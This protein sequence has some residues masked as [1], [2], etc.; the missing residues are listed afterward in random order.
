MTLGCRWPAPCWWAP[1]CYPPPQQPGEGVCL[2]W[3]TPTKVKTR[4]PWRVPPIS[5][6]FRGLWSPVGVPG[7]W[8][9]WYLWCGHPSSWGSLC[10]WCL[11]LQPWFSQFSRFLLNHTVHLWGPLWAFRCQRSCRNLSPPVRPLT[12]WTSRGMA[13]PLSLS[14]AGASSVTIC[15]NSVLLHYDFPAQ[16]QLSWEVRGQGA[17]T[18]NP[19]WDLC[20]V[21]LSKGCYSTVGPKTLFPNLICSLICR[22]SG[23]PWISWTWPCV[24]NIFPWA[25]S[26]GLSACYVHC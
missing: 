24:V 5:L 21:Y 22:N 2:H 20:P 3:V 15:L 18:T 16:L 6:F 11:F 19:G 10:C 4:H 1:T 9:L 8:L 13:F 17:W 7:L 26:F 25:Y 12:D 14:G 23:P